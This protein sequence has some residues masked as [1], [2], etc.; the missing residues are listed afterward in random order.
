MNG[1][2]MSVLCGGIN[3]PNVFLYDSLLVPAQMKG[4]IGREIIGRP[5]VLP[6]YRR[7]NLKL[8]NLSHPLAIEH[9]K[10]EI[11]GQV[12]E[13]TEQELLLIDRYQTTAIDKKSLVLKSGIVAFAYVRPRIL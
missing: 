4:V 9:E 6:G 10:G 8:P 11:E 1:Q 7:L 2:M 13:V 12:F 3:M 5:D